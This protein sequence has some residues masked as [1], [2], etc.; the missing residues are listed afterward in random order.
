MSQE[1]VELFDRY[2]LA[3]N[4]RALA[5]I[6]DLTHA[7]FEFVSILSAVDEVTYSGTDA[8]TEYFAAMDQTWEEWNTDDFRVLDAGD[9][10]IAVICRLAGT[11]R[12]GGV[13]VER[14]IGMTC[15]LRDGKFWRMR[16]YLDPADALA[17]AGLGD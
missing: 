16:S 15:T 17:A 11:S 2:A 10:Q 6:A 8:W 12:H 7:D 9:D 4:R 5:D 3:F 13:P 14:E 1:N